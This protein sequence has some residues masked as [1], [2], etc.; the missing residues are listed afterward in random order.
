MTKGN[1]LRLFEAFGVEL[2]Y[3]IVAIDTLDVLPIADE[4]L[5]SVTGAYA[6]EAIRG[7]MAWSNELALH[8]LELKVNGPAPSLTGLAPAFDA[9]VGAVQRVLA[10]LGARLMPTSMHPWMNPDRDLRLWPHGDRTIYETFNRIFDCRGH[11]WANLQSAHLNL[12]FSNDEEF[13]RLHAAIRLVLPL[14]PA[15]AASS[16]IADGGYTGLLDSRL[17]FYR[18]NAIAIPSVTGHVIPERV[19]SQRNYVKDILE[20][21]YRDMAELDRGG[22]LRHEWVNSRGAIARFDRMALEIRILDIQECPMA[23]LAI[24]AAATA[25]V[26]MLV[27]EE[28]ISWADQMSWDEHRLATL[29]RETMRDAD[30]AV[31]ADSEYLDVFGYKSSG[32]Q[33]TAGELWGHLLEMAAP[34][35]AGDEWGEFFRVWAAHGTLSRR[36]RSALGEQPHRKAIREVYGEL[37]ECLADHRLFVP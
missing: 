11:G 4:V 7:P 25:V 29:L 32:G 13:S 17:D 26:R 36:I 37:C 28:T 35:D 6:M 8:V 15:L 18:H 12:P 31:I 33:R 10:P 23:D 21:I 1:V 20:P 22:V 30:A 14:L 16:P 19:F 2:E 24:A 3:M 5:K 34:P 27:Q 9:E